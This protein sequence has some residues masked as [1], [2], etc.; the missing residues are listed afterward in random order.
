M[1]NH[2]QKIEM[3]NLGWDPE[4]QLGELMPGDFKRVEVFQDPLEAHH[5]D[6]FA[7]C[8]L[9]KEGKVDLDRFMAFMKILLRRSYLEGMLK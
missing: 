3:I 6:L 5:R 8:M 1:S 2:H 4:F 7:A 9:M